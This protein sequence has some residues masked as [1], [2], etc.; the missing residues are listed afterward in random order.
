M[1]GSMSEILIA[2]TA[3]LFLVRHHT[4]RF[5][6]SNHPEDAGMINWSVRLLQQVAS[7][8][9]RVVVFYDIVKERSAS[10]PGKSIRKVVNEL[11]LRNVEV[12]EYSSLDSQRAMEVWKK[13]IMGLGGKWDRPANHLNFNY[14][15]IDTIVSN[16]RFLWVDANGSEE[17][18]I[19][20]EKVTSFMDLAKERES[21]A[22]W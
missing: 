20:P 16:D 4:G 3:D 12:V 1:G 14:M 15:N 10:W 13:R 2:K 7:Q 21:K 19:I 8:F 5:M 11:G 6:T 22:I 9:S 18:E 17:N